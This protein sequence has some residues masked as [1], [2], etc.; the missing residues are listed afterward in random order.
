MLFVKFSHTFYV[1][2]LETQTVIQDYVDTEADFVEPNSFANEKDPL[3]FEQ[4]FN[5]QVEDLD[6]EVGIGYDDDGDDDDETEN[7]DCQDVDEIEENLM[8][9]EEAAMIRLLDDVDSATSN[10]FDLPTTST[11]AYNR[12]SK[13][14]KTAKTLTNTFQRTTGTSKKN[15]EKETTLVV[16]KSVDTNSKLPAKQPFTDLTSVRSASKEPTFAQPSRT[17]SIVTQLS[18]TL[19]LMPSTSTQLTTTQSTSS[20]QATPQPVSALQASSQP[21]SKTRGRPKG[22]KN[23]THSQGL[24]AAIKKISS[25]F[26]ICV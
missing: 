4:D 16:L 12:E 6:E 20:I 18:S 11:N 2:L 17:Q 8:T 25:I 7:E 21:T 26:F 14:A 9:T 22:S 24:K 1:G 5:Q 10:P 19:N 23:K 3:I 15:K 13:Q